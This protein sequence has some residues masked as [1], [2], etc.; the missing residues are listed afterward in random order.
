MVLIAYLNRMR[1]LFRMPSVLLGRFLINLRNIPDHRTRSGDSSE[2]IQ[3]ASG[4]RGFHDTIIN[5]AAPLGEPVDYE[6][7]DSWSD[8]EDNEVTTLADFGP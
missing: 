8:S 1:S 2:P 3:F 6:A 5:M 4:R 7:G